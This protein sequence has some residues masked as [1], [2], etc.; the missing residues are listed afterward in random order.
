MLVRKKM[1]EMLIKNEIKE[2]YEAIDGE[3]AVIKYADKTP[4]VVFMD[5]VMPKKT[6]VE[7]LKDIK[8]LNPNA[9]VIMA[10]SI[11]T[12]GNLKE[13]IDNGAY[14][15]IQK[16]ISEEILMKVLNKIIE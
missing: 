5:I 10:S 3:D 16:P 6:G 8:S 1:R 9:K 15:F 13:A 11:G 4:D 14:D 2:I 12:Q 7:A